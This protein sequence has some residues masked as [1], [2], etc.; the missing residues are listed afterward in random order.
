MSKAARH[1]ARMAEMDFDT[2]QRVKM[3]AGGRRGTAT[4]ALPPGKSP[5]MQQ[6]CPN[7]LVFIQWD[8]DLKGW[9]R[10][11]ELEKTGDQSGTLG[12]DR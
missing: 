6:H 7:G 1:V 8:D 11:E 4:N 9:H 3:I 12:G 10:V 2:G 5:L